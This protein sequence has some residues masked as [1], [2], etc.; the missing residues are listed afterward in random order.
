MRVLTRLAFAIAIVGAGCVDVETDPGEGPGELPPPGPTVEFDPG[1][2]I[3]PFPNNLVRDRTTGRVTLPPQC[4]ESPTQ[5]ALREGVLN[6]LD[7]FGAFKVPLRFT[8]T[9]AVDMASLA[10]HV[11]MFAR[12]PASSTEVPIVAIPSVTVRYDESCGNPTMVPA[13]IVVPR[14]PLQQKT[15][16]VVG[17][18]NGLMTAEGTAF[19]PATVWTLVRQASNPVTV[20][21]SGNVVAD[22]TP[23][24]PSD[25]AEREQLLGIDLLWK[26]HAMGVAHL[27]ANGVANNDILLA[28]E[29]TTQTL[30]DPLDPTVAGSPASEIAT[31]PIAA[32]TSVPPQLGLTVRDFLCIQVYGIPPPPGNPNYD[33]QCTATCNQTGCAAVGDIAA[34]GVT[35]KNY[36]QA[37]PGP[38]NP[39]PGPWND[40]YHPTNAADDLLRVLIVYPATPPPAAGY[41]TIIFG[42]GLG[43]DKQSL[44]A[45]APQLASQG[46]ASVSVDFV[47]HGDP[48]SPLGGRAV[49]ISNM[50]AMGCGA[51]S[52]PGNAP[53]CFAPIL[54]ANLAGTRDNLRQTILDIQRVM[55]AA[56][57][58]GTTMCG[59]LE[60]DATKV[61]YMGIS[62]GGIIGTMTAASANPPVAGAV[63]NVA[64]VGWVDIIE[65]TA[66]VQIKCPLVDALIAA[67][68]IVGE[69]WD[70]VGGTG[71]CLGEEWK[72][73]PGYLQFAAAARWILDPADGVNFTTKLVMKPTLLQEVMG[74]LVVP[75]VATD[76]LGALTGRTPAQ[77]DPFTGTEGPSAAI[78]TDPTASLWVQYPDLPPAS[79]F[80][81]NDFHHASLLRPN[82]VGGQPPTP[83]ERLATGRMQ[84]DAI[85]Y[86]VLTICLGDCTP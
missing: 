4:N 6:T 12:D 55:A 66:T 15:T 20:D 51:G 21:A 59:P 5:T 48:A 11:V 70:P 56:R 25:Q 77:A 37:T 30:T 86:L 36:Q 73:Q 42:H 43:S 16:Y 39:I 57:A 85:G 83:A 28:W 76:Q 10:D 9:D 41:P 82:A 7:G 84:T 45:I 44:L 52:T 38:I 1:N 80:P 53:Q 65:N 58:C 67:G 2:S 22:R 68:V 63:T 35:Y 62:L 13:V 49:R 29:F 23:L 75:N 81:G 32:I 54:S 17:I 72:T 27:V 74:D 47:A 64:A 50:A 71:T 8:T 34:G 26:A 79:P 14:V 18:T 46:F 33:A 24:D 78:G 40:P 69:P 60:V 3:I 19:A 31:S 61:G